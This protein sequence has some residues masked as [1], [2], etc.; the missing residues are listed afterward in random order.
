MFHDQHLDRIGT[1]WHKPKLVRASRDIR[2]RLF[3]S[4]YIDQILI[5]T[6]LS[7]LLRIDGLQLL[8]GR[9]GLADLAQVEDRH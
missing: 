4:D 8:I 5:L 7:G 3:L 6:F 1:G 9:D 2:R